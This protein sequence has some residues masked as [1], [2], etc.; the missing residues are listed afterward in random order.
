MQYGEEC[1]IG[2]FVTAQLDWRNTVRLGVTDRI[3][4]FLRESLRHAADPDPHAVDLSNHNF[5][6][7]ALFI[8]QQYP[9]QQYL[10][11]DLH[12]GVLPHFN[13]HNTQFFPSL[14]VCNNPPT[15]TREIGHERILYN[16][17]G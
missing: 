2:A 11:Y 13:F 7:G 15:L 17:P 1:S 3:R 5:K 8:F 10:N 6:T 9:E 4:N 12:L 14:F 16:D